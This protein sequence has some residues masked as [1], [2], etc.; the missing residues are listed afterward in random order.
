MIFSGNYTIAKNLV[1]PLEAPI[2]H[3][4]IKVCLSKSPKFVIIILHETEV[5]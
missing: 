3:N 1:C 5:F 2:K 4:K